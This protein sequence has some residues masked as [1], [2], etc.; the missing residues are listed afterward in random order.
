MVG[1]RVACCVWISG[2]AGRDSEKYILVHMCRF[3]TVVFSTDSID[4][5]WTGPFQRTGSYLLECLGYPYCMY[6][7]TNHHQLDPPMIDEFLINKHGPDTALY[8]CI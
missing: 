1:G 2:G 5:C 3:S 6:I 8:V 7:C 4:E